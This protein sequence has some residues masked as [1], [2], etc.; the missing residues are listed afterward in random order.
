MNICPIHKSYLV[1]YCPQCGSNILYTKTTY[2]KPIDH[3][4]RCNTLFR[5]T[6]S[7][8]CYFEQERISQNWLLLA[9]LKGRYNLDQQTYP[10]PELFYIL[11]ILSRN[12]LRIN[13][14]YHQRYLANLNTD[15]L[16]QIIQDSVKSIRQGS[17][18]IKKF[19][20]KNHLIGNAKFF[21]KS[22]DLSLLP[23]WL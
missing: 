23:N 9:A 20:S 21:E 1:N 6:S 11:R 18:G 17:M 16:S 3:C 22:D 7:K 14:K 12:I 5:E 10:S 19:R 8:E 15:E 4:C 2:S 13:E